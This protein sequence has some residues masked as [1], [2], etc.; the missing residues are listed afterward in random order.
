MSEPTRTMSPVADANCT[1]SGYKI[2][3]DRATARGILVTNVPYFCVE[4]Q[5]DHTLAADPAKEQ[6]LSGTHR[7]LPEVQLQAAR[8]ERQ[9]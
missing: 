3:V 5:A 7:D 1:E 4:E 2:A 6:R 9:R 8:P